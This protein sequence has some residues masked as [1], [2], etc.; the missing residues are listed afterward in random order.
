MS[1]LKG[2]THYLGQSDHNELCLKGTTHYLG[3]SE[4][5]VVF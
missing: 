5:W 2:A 4:Q 1:C 3:Q